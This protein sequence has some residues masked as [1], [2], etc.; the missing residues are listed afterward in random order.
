MF[1]F[2]LGEYTAE[3]TLP[4][5]LPFLKIYQKVVF[6]PFNVPSVAISVLIIADI[7]NFET[8]LAN[9]FDERFRAV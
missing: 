9:S 5:F 6:G 7:G 2:N 8:S 4:I 3:V 1:F